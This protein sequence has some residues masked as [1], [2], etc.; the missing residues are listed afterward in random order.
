M[1]RA[2]S[3]VCRVFLTLNHRKAQRVSIYAQTFVAPVVLLLIC[4]RASFLFSFIF[5]LKKRVFYFS[6][7]VQYYFVPVSSMWAPFFLFPFLPCVRV[8]RQTPCLENPPW[9]KK[10]NTTFQPW[11][12]FFCSTNS[13]KLWE[14]ILRERQQFCFPGAANFVSLFSCFLRVFAYA[15]LSIRGK[16]ERRV[17]VWEEKKTSFLVI[18][19]KKQ[20][21]WDVSRRACATSM[22]TSVINDTL[23]RQ[24]RE[25]KQ[26]CSVYFSLCSAFDNSITD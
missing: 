10:K 24:A 22:E 1:L 8:P 11:T 2:F 5:L 17:I 23:L 7:L 6:H 26:S 3:Q 18:A 20:K 19:P 4:L 21:Y 16:C 14:W 25:Y 13:D 9:K 12:F 15:F